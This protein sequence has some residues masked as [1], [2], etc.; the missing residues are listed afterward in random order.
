MSAYDQEIA[1]AAAPQ[2]IGSGQ[3][4]R[5]QRDVIRDVML[6]AYRYG[7]WLTLEEIHGFVRY[8][9]PSISAQLRHLWDEGFVLEKRRRELLYSGTNDGRGHVLWEYMIHKQ[10]KETKP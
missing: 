7:Y 9:V 1:K 3:R 6:V 8:P 5:T 2:P 10:G 4:L